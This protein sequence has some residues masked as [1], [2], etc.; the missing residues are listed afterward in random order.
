[1]A[2]VFSKLTG[3]K[4]PKES[5]WKGRE[6]H[7]AYRRYESGRLAKQKENLELYRNEKGI[8]TERVV[9]KNAG[10]WKAVIN[11][12]T[13]KLVDKLPTGQMD[14]RPGGKAVG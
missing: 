2:S 8:E 7:T 1:M 14:Y 5:G 13:G 11:H 6:S 10:S 3:R 4:A 12:S 9:A